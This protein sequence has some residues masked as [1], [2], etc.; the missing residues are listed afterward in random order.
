[1]VAPSD[2][3]ERA[4]QIRDFIFGR[5]DPSQTVIQV[6]AVKAGITTITGVLMGRSDGFPHFPPARR[7]PPLYALVALNGYGLVLTPRPPTFSHYG[8]YGALAKS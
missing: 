2:P 4:T 8:V 5:T 1:M 6:Q 7:N 3:G